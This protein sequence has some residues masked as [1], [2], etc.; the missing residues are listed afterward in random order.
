MHGHSLWL[1]DSFSS[2]YQVPSQAD[3]DIGRCW[4]WRPPH[5]VWG[6][7]PLWAFGNWPVCWRSDSTAGPLGGLSS[8]SG[9]W[10]IPCRGRK[11]GWKEEHQEHT[12]TAWLRFLSSF[13][14]YTSAFKGMF[15]FS[16]LKPVC[17]KVSTFII[18]ITSQP[19]ALV[20]LTWEVWHVDCL[21]RHKDGDNP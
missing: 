3:R 8:P 21:L 11:E 1:L 12:T 7:P 17:L 13:L 9:S 5:D 15:L 4:G 14:V 10:S 19:S 2:T 6:C 16:L 20:W 18:N